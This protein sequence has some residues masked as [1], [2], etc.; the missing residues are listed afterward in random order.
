MTQA[1]RASYLDEPELEKLSQLRA[2]TDQQLQGLVHSKLDVG[3]T[4]AARAEVEES[5]KALDE[6]QRLL[7]ALNEEQRRALR[8]KLTE[9]REALDRL[10][11]HRASGMTQADERNYF[12]DC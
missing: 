3:L 6:V 2:K 12:C 5:G 8:P 7:P 4:F 11:R 1:F 10:G 9:L